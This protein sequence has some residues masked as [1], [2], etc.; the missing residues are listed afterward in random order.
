MG[1]LARLLLFSEFEFVP[2]ITATSFMSNKSLAEFVAFKWLV[3]VLLMSSSATA[4]SGGSSCSK[5]VDKMPNST[6]YDKDLRPQFGAI[7]RREYM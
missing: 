2:K 4:S 7:P 6:C 3:V 5:L 1:R